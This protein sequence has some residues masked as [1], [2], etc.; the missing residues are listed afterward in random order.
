MDNDVQSFSKTGMVFADPQTG[1]LARDPQGVD[2]TPHVFRTTDAGVTWTR[3]DLPAPA[4]APDLYDTYACSSYSPNAFSALSA[5]LAMKCL[6]FLPPPSKL[7]R[8][9]PIPPPMAA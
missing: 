8:I 5:A 6:G 3:L 7:K 1:W 9:L 2:P 4:A